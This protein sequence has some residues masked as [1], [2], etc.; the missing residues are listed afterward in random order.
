MKLSFS[1]EDFLSSKRMYVSFEYDAMDEG[2]VRLHIGGLDLSSLQNIKFVISL[3]IV[4][5][6]FRWR[7]VY[8]F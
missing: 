4:S 5:C 2:E 3:Q 6:L 1:G 7:F 8:L